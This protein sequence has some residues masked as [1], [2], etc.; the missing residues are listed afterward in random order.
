MSMRAF[1]RSCIVALVALLPALSSRAG[2]QE[3]E[4]D[5]KDLEVGTVKFTGNRTF[6]SDVL[7]DRVL[8]TPSSLYRRIF[9]IFGT[10]RC[11]PSNGLAPDVA[12]G[13]DAPYT[14]ANTGAAPTRTATSPASGTKRLIAISSS[15]CGCGR[16]YPTAPFAPRHAIARPV[17]AGTAFIDCV[18]PGRTAPCPGR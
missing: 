9:K 11:L 17:P 8:I 3:I 10:R 14:D 12:I 7:A 18:R 2:A 4:C 6:S 13:A 16:E 5:E 1:G 15:R